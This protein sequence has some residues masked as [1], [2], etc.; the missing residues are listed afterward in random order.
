MAD[1]K[2]GGKGNK[3]GKKRGSKTEFFDVL[4]IIVGS[5]SLFTAFSYLLGRLHIEDYYHALGINPSVLSFSANDYMFFSFDLIIMCL[6]VIGCFYVYWHFGDSDEYKK[7]IEE[8]STIIFF[9]PI[10]IGILVYFSLLRYFPEWYQT[11]LTGFSFGLFYGII[12]IIYI[13]LSNYFL[14][15]FVEYIKE[16]ATKNNAQEKATKVSMQNKTANKDNAQKKAT[17]VS[18]Q[19]KIARIRS[20]IIKIISRASLLIVI[21]I[22]IVSLPQIIGILAEAKAI[23]EM[24]D[25]SEVKVVF[26][27]NF[28][29]IIEGKLVTTNNNMTYVLVTENNSEQWQVYSIPVDSIIEI[30]YFHISENK[31]WWQGF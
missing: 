1:N 17:K 18:I 11:G 29:R 20:N 21:V 27:E 2:G 8:K 22:I 19:K 26:S 13:F 14:K 30:T 9:L 25:F 3:K 10:F 23:K 28:T 15:H 12:P 31:S 6:V 16:N 7:M 4:K 5:V 24:K